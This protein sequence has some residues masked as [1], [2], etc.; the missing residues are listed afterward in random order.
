LRASFS[1]CAI[2]DFLTTFLSV[3][4]HLHFLS[5]ILISKEKRKGLLSLHPEET[6]GDP[7]KGTGRSRRR[8]MRIPGEKDEDPARET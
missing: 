7:E 8:H 5:T 6:R 3:R 1:R 2:L 4:N